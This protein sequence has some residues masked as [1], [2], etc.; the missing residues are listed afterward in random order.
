MFK[1]I[2]PLM[3]VISS[4]QANNL[5]WLGGGG[6]PK[7]DTT[8]FDPT[9]RELAQ[10]KQRT[11]LKLDIVFDGGHSETKKIISNEIKVPS[12][13]FTA[14]NYEE[15]IKGYLDKIKK[16]EIKKGEQLIVVM[17]THGGDQTASR[18][19]AE[20][21]KTHSIALAG[22]EIKDFTKITGERSTSM[23][24]MLELTKVAKEFGVRLGIVDL[25]CHSGHSLSL[26]NENTCVI[27]STGPNHFAYTTFANEFTKQIQKGKSLEDVFLDA[28]KNSSDASFPMIS[29]KTG[30]IL[31]EKFYAPFSDY[32]HFKYDD[33]ADK[34]TPLLFNLAQ[35]DRLCKREE[36]FQQLLKDI[37][38]LE[39]ITGSLKSKYAG[40][41]D[42]V[43]ELKK[44]KKI[45]D[46]LALK[47]K[48]LGF[49]KVN[50]VES[51]SYSIKT[52][53]GVVK[54]ESENISWDTIMLMYPASSISYFE[55]LAKK[56]TSPKEREANLLTAEKFKQIDKKRQEI[57]K[58]YPGLKEK[59]SITAEINK[60]QDELSKKASAV[61]QLSR[62]VYDFNYLSE[63]KRAKDNFDPCSTIKF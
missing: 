5:V 28:R 34:L 63:R 58:L 2:I 15:T 7:K 54:K 1:K 46:Q 27:T 17:D 29:N 44:Y 36:S 48:Q 56:A 52:K 40:E 9:L 25:S 24:K 3:I 59:G 14:K 6:E 22:G 60:L 12:K 30:K 35:E 50:K 49:D 8:I 47:I 20:N 39:K 38:Q 16:G 42:L 43:E 33:S 10:A 18:T 45:Q 23:D 13:D 21:H 11:D 31:N 32:L 41:E 26:A 51:I 53:S 62:K 55:D 4:I 57:Y 37:E 61:S 19:G